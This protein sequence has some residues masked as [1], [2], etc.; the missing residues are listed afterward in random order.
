MKK[1]VIAFALLCLSVVIYAQSSKPKEKPAAKPAA[2]PTAPAAKSNA[3][4]AFR[5]NNLGAAYMNQ[6]EF[7]KALKYFEQAAQVDPKFE[8]AKLNQGI[9]LLNLQKTEQAL[10][11]LQDAIKRNPNNA[12]A[13]Y[14]LGLLYKN[15]GD[16][17]SA[18]D[19]F[20]HAVDAAPD[21]P[22][23][24]YFLCL[25]LSQSGQNEAAIKQFEQAI[26]LNPFHASA[27]FGIATA[28]RRLGNQEHAK[29]HLVRFQHLTQ[30]KI[31]APITLAYGDQG[32]LSLVSMVAGK[33]TE[34]EPPIA[35][36]FASVGA[37]AGLAQ[38]A[39]ARL[40]SQPGEFSGRGA[41]FLDYDNDGKPDVFLAAG[42]AQGGAAL[43]HNSGNGH[44][45][46]VTK[47]AGLSSL[48]DVV[49]C[50]AADY[51]S[52]GFVDL[53]IAT[54][55]G[56][57]L[58]HNEHT[59]TFKDV[60]STAG[61]NAKSDSIIG[62]TWIDYD[63]DG[64][65]DLYVVGGTAKNQMW[66][67]NGNSTFTD[68]T[69]DLGFSGEANSF[70]AVGSDVN[71]DRAV[72]IV[73][74]GE[75]LQMFKNPREGK[76]S[77]ER[78]PFSSVGLAVLDY[79]KDGWMD[80]AIAEPNGTVA[81]IRNE[82]GRNFAP[83]ELPNFRWQHAWGITAID[84]DNDGWIDLAGVGETKDGK[85]EVRLL[86]NEGSEGFR[87]VSAEVGL[88]KLELKEP[89][90][91]FAADYDGDG[92]T[93]LLITQNSGP[94]VLL[95]ND[96]GNK[97]NSLRIEL[98]G[99]NDNKTG[100]GTKIEI[101]AGTLSQKFEI[102][103]AGYLGQSAT[104][105]V[106]GLGKN[107]QLDVVRMLWPTGVVQDEIEV[108]LGKPADIMEIDRRGSSCPI[109]FAWDGTRYRF[110]SDMIGAGVVG[111]WVGPNERN[112]PD[113]T[114]Y[115]KVDGDIVKQKNGMLSFRFMEPMEEVVYIDQLR[116]LAVD[117][118]SD[119]NVEPNEYFA[120]NP[121]YPE[122]KVISSGTRD[123]RLPAGAWDDSGRNVLP[124]LE[125]R[126]REYVTGFKLL[127][128][129]A[130]YAEPHNLTLDLG[131]PYEGG[132]LRLLLHGFIEYFT[133]TS[134]FS[135]HQAGIDPVAPYIEAEVNGKWVK[136][137]EDMGFP[138]GLPRTTVAD[139]SG[140]LPRGTQ[141]IRIATNLQIYWDQ[142][143][144]DRTQSSP[145][146]NLHEVPLASAKLAFH[147]Y[148]L[149]RERGKNVPGDHYYTYE[150]V[151]PTGPY[152]RQA[153]A[154][155]RT[156]DVLN[157]VNA[158]DDRFAVFGSG[159]VIKL[160]FDPSNLPALPKGWTR[161]YF[162]FA[163]GFEKD[164]DFYAADGLTVDPLP[165]H[166]MGTYPYPAEKTYW[167]DAQHV[168]TVLDMNTRFYGNVP[169]KDFRY[170]YPKRLKN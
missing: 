9:A 99:L 38:V 24:H 40:R 70:E 164:M 36:K 132:T 89:R 119:Y 140:K 42:S 34:V 168:D 64:D 21:D 22:D 154:Y 112:I 23:S 78:F 10:P 128:N 148:P 165:F 6:Q 125:K 18:V 162:F 147:G 145:E 126:D 39:P 46:D 115:F 123:L 118:P 160:D 153:G 67:N 131:R 30:T 116:L 159:D 83:V 68:I 149:D 59:G 137:V 76:W 74:S 141:R 120:A 13:W 57:E 114:E 90:G 55:T 29:Q 117:H 97:N 27:E 44:F 152:V 28:Y 56:V 133:A 95:R 49:T 156:G 121:P 48:S 139:L 11:F 73:V 109:L 4:E 170:H 72:D 3:A 161:D 66:R 106:V 12:R 26:K 45:E 142:V 98:K 60:T 82:A 53:A 91:I 155:T 107:K 138:A 96:G 14:N 50:A 37:E 31:G 8:E 163:D 143:L 85:F 71:N 88:D 86:R 52:D 51:D 157:L 61:L 33:E 104:D 129:Y 65:V 108:A 79:N 136:V 105:L 151:S 15:S 103:G 25:T 166:A 84:Y 7:A 43:Y 87:D 101:F 113:P 124:L 146:V 16:A 1:A 62:L 17:K 169:P 69:P 63:H 127:R 2:K 134:M 111:H 100:V 144:I 77:P 94:T 20:Q 58:L 167:R 158:S 150:V 41:C 102:T 80:W 19:A 130:G 75:P 35:V 47:S 110:I 32:P 81:L 54:T 92:D 122:F 93:D 135:A 5:L